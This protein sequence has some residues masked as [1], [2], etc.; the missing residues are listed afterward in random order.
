MEN[1]MPRHLP[2]IYP[3]QQVV[4]PHFFNEPEPAS[5]NAPKPRMSKVSPDLDTLPKN[6]YPH[7]W[8]RTN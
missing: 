2:E 7:V 3:L 1:F 4:F 8:Q 6:E 5:Q